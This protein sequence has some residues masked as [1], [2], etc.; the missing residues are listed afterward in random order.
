MAHVSS[1]LYKRALPWS[2]GIRAQKPLTPRQVLIQSAEMVEAFP[3]GFDR[4]HAPSLGNKLQSDPRS[5]TR[6]L[7]RIGSHWLIIS[8]PAAVVGVALMLFIRHE[9]LFFRPGAAKNAK[10]SGCSLRVSPR[11]DRACPALDQDRTHPQHEGIGNAQESRWQGGAKHVLL[12]HG[13]LIRG[14]GLCPRLVAQQT[15]S[16]E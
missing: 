2:L 14:G 11:H 8:M 13:Q 10:L 6:R 3:I 15:S 9:R 1:R 16:N 7:Q 4:R 5:R 12:L